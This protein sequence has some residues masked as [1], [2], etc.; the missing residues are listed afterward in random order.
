LLCFS[1]AH[2]GKGYGVN[3]W[4]TGNKST[5]QEG[6]K[7]A[8]CQGMEGIMGKPRRKE[9]TGKAPAPALHSNQLRTRHRG[10]QMHSVS[11]R[12]QQESGN[13][14][15]DR[16][17]GA[18]LWPPTTNKF[19]YWITQT[20]QPRDQDLLAFQ[21][22]SKSFLFPLLGGVKGMLR[23]GICLVVAHLLEVRAS[24]SS[25]RANQIFLTPALLYLQVPSCRPGQG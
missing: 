10:H 14:E 18:G 2:L 4:S 16:E 11:G 22:D 24:S 1:P 19:C 6:R 5:R 3:P 8:Q 9:G 21:L 7:E 23:K 12:L 15:T 20:F 13:T 25:P 17:D